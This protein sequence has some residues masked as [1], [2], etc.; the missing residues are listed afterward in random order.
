M[1]IIKLTIFV[2]NILLVIPARYG[3]TRLPG[4]PLYNL[5][6]VSMIERVWT[7][8]KKVNHASEVIVATDHKDIMKKIIDVGGKAMITS[9][10]HTSGTDRMIEVAER[11]ND[12]DYYLNVQGDEPGIDPRQIETL[13]E[14]M[15][16]NEDEIATQCIKIK[17]ANDLFDY[18]I[19]KV[20]RDENH[21]AMYF[22]R[23]A[24][25][26]FR[27]EL[28]K[29]WIN[30]ATYY[31]HVGLYG[32]SREALLEV[33]KLKAGLLESIESLEQLRWLEQGMSI[34]VYETKYDSI[35]IDTQEDA[36]RYIERL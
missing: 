13:I 20:V 16:A 14:N 12:Y 4:K 29:D 22:S 3:S 26:A 21:R 19:V 9:E 2:I 23:N 11:Y 7:Q 6:G 1:Q 34:K 8:C 33:G 28:Y 24:I 5:G 18:N 30:R 32:F 27:N 35:S 10:T 31:K 25:P 15:V 36:N 17:H